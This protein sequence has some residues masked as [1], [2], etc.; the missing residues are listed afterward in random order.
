MVLAAGGFEK[1]KAMRDQYLPKPTDTHWSAGV[2]TNTGDAVN[3]GMAVGAG[4]L[5]RARRIAWT[6]GTMAAPPG[7]GSSVR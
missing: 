4:N 3:A 6:A 7:T 2:S 1:N 5:A